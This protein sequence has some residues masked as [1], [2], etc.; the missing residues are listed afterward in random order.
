VDKN[1]MPLK[2]ADST[3]SIKIDSNTERSDF[4][5]NKMKPANADRNPMKRPVPSPDAVQKP[6][7]PPT[8]NA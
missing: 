8:K 7:V 3:L 1:V 4:E 2:K 5:L 6:V